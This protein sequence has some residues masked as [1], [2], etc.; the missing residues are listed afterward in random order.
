MQSICTGK[1]YILNK[2]ICLL[3][4]HLNYSKNRVVLAL[5]SLMA[6]NMFVREMVL[7]LT[8]HSLR[9]L[10]WTA[11]RKT[12]SFHSSRYF[13]LCLFTTVQVL[14]LIYYFFFFSISIWDLK[15]VLQKY[16]TIYLI[17]FII[18]FRGLV[19]QLSPGLRK[20]LNF[21]TTH[22]TRGTFAGIL[23]SF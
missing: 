15:L 9:R 16:F 5:R 3:N 13:Q 12:L 4:N 7:F 19:L 23:R 10:K 1:F 22:S 11:L 2:F 6:L 17:V 20:G 8:F 21:F 18:S 14:L